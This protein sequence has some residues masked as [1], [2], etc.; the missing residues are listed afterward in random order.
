MN[1]SKKIIISLV[2]ILTVA[3]ILPGTSGRSSVEGKTNPYLNYTWIT[4]PKDGNMKLK[5]K[6]TSKKAKWKSSNKKI[7]TVNKNGTVTG[8]KDG[9]CTI[10]VTVSGK[11]LKCKVTVKGQAKKPAKKAFTK[12]T[13]NVL[14]LKM[15]AKDVQFDAEGKALLSDKPGT[16]KLSILNSSK[17][18]KWTSSNSKV[19]TVK[20]G[21][22]TAVSAGKC[23][24]SATIKK[25]KYKCTVNVTN[26]N[27]AEKIAKQKAI[28]EML[29]YINRDRVKVKVAPLKIK[30]EVN[31]VADIR[32]AE[33]ATENNFTHTRPGE[34]AY[35]TAYDDAGIK[36][37]TATGEN[38]AFVADKTEY[39]S[40][41]TKKTYVHLYNQK[42]HKELMMNPKYDYI[43]ISFTKSDVYQDG[44]GASSVIT[45]WAQEFYIK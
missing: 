11:K 18:A 20:N 12:V 3:F 15:N 33:I 45:Y 25:T 39:M 1:G 6:G 32:A 40:E 19:A 38:L 31:R 8:K 16:F 36:R 5:V 41:F 28:Y 42:E 4:V 29:D 30:E 9:K 35:Y 43:G 22:V 44:S 10:T 24:I 17:K 37:G 14:E 34:K 27:D 13:L 26:L 2:L 21:V 23:T 7:A